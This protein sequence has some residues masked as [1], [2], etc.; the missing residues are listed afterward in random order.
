MFP[1]AARLHTTQDIITTLRKGHRS[2]SGPVT[3]SVLRKGGTLGR[4]AV[5]VDSKVSKRA[6]VR[7]LVKRRTRAA[8][9]ELT[10]PSGDM[11]V[12]LAPPARN[13]TYQQLR[14]QLNQCLKRV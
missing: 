3:C 8:L 4:V 11:V 14:E 9:R 7:N 5:I 1:Q 13:L 12:R 2:A 6:I 10:L